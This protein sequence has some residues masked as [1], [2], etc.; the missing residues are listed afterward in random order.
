MNCI[1]VEVQI[2]HLDSL[3][4]CLSLSPISTQTLFGSDVDYLWKVYL[5][6]ENHF[7]SIFFFIFPI[8]LHCFIGSFLIVWCYCQLRDKDKIHVNCSPI[9]ER[10]D[11]KVWSVTF[12]TSFNNKLHFQFV[13]KS[14]KSFKGKKFHACVLCLVLYV[15]HF[16]PKMCANANVPLVWFS[17]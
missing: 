8:F 5:S 13:P 11:R 10:C 4:E 14:L 16:K 12:F 3:T 7:F 6:E 2:K 9:D 17:K 1:I 15:F